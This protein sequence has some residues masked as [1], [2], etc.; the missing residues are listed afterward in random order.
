MEVGG[1]DHSDVH[2]NKLRTLEAGYHLFLD[3]E[4]QGTQGGPRSWRI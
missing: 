4:S 1:Y 2:D 3:M